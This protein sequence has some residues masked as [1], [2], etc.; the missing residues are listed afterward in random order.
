MAA[1]PSIQRLEMLPA[2]AFSTKKIHCKRLAMRSVIIL[3]CCFLLF[4][5]SSFA[6]QKISGIVSGENN[7]PLAGATIT[8]KGSNITTLSLDDGSFNITVKTGD[9]LEI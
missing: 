4:C 2:T 5:S 9:I 8:I 3:T 7:L 1:I 6:Q